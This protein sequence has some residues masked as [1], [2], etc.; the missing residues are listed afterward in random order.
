MDEKIKFWA[1][2]L[3]IPVVLAIFGYLIN[4][5]LQNKAEALD[6]AKYADE[7][8]SETFDTTNTVRALAR[9]ELL[10]YLV[11][12]K[13]FVTDLTASVI[14]FFVEKA[15]EAARSGHDS[16]YRSISDLAKCFKGNAHALDS[17]LRINKHTANAEKAVEYERSAL[18]SLNSGKIMS[19]KLLFDSAAMKHPSF[20]SNKEIADTLKKKIN[21]I[22]DPVD[23]EKVKI[24][25]QNFIDA[26]YSY[27][28]NPIPVHKPVAPITNPNVKGK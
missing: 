24:E 5:S 20:K 23:S 25:T 21:N 22:K 12:D 14:N 7:L 16:L 18:D 9:V 11:S 13:K 8:I 26:K 27:K 4:N 2:A 28:N 15:V 19:A 17:L 10:P 3:I 1:T 6:K